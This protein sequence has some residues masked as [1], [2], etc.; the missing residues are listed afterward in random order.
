[1]KM[2]HPALA[3]ISILLATHVGDAFSRDYQRA[4]EVSDSFILVDVDQLRSMMLKGWTVAFVKTVRHYKTKKNLG[5][6]AEVQSEGYF[7]VADCTDKGGVKFIDRRFYDSNLKIIK[8]IDYTEGD[9][10]NLSKMS[11]T[12]IIPGS[13]EFIAVD[14]ACSWIEA[15]K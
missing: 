9:F 2:Y 12:K 13:A 14:Y 3:I 6:G 11:R 4:G 5:L 8:E 1:M 10:N 15:N 7:M